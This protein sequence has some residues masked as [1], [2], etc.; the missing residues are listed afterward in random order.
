MLRRNRWLLGTRLL[1]I[2]HCNMVKPQRGSYTGK[3]WT[4]DCHQRY[5]LGWNECFYPLFKGLQMFSCILLSMVIWKAYLAS[6]PRRRAVE[7]TLEWST[8][9]AWKRAAYM[10]TAEGRLEKWERSSLPCLSRQLTVCLTNL[11]KSMCLPLFLV[12]E[13]LRESNSLTWMRAVGTPNCERPEENY[14]S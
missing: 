13:W 2:K 9:C 6:R 8:P 3:S 1:E 4:D 14:Q 12:C 10:L 5:K 7:Y 11:N